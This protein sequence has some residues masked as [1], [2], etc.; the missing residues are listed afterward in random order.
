M[1]N[2]NIVPRIQII[3]HDLSVPGIREIENDK[4]NKSENLSFLYQVLR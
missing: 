1:E 4:M 3:E 2:I